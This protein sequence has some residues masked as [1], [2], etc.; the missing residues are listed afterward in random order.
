MSGVGYASSPAFML[1]RH[2]H[3][4]G[5]ACNFRRR[6]RSCTEPYGPCGRIPQHPFLHLGSDGNAGTACVHAQIRAEQPHRSAHQPRV[7][8]A[9]FTAN[10][11][12]R[13]STLV[14][15]LPL[16][17]RRKIPADKSHSRLYSP[18]P[19]LLLYFSLFLL[20]TLG[21]DDQHLAAVARH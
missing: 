13:L 17:H 15:R 18:L 5:P 20:H 7:R 19:F 11:S 14:H 6:C 1:A 16:K 8:L 21:D 10:L 12:T 4:P 9:H 2:A 3:V